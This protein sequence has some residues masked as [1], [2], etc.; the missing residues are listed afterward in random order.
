MFW[1]GKIT[2]RQKQGILTYLRI[3][4]SNPTQADY[5]PINLL[6]SDYKIQARMVERR[7][8]PTIEDQLTYT[9]YCVIPGY[10][11][12]DAVATGCDSIAYAES[13]KK[14]CVFSLD[15]KNAFDRVSHGYLFKIIHGY[16]IGSPLINGIWHLCEGATSSKQIND[17]QYGPIPVRCA[18][19]Q[20]C[21]MSMALYKLSLHSLLKVLEQ[22]LPGLRMETKNVTHRL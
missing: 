6:N 20:D 19:R 13:K 5:R 3:P 10:T 9:Q 14:H 2:S 7:L 15:F 18:V 11:L 17:H 4:R 12:L 1:D 16:G 8:R 22:K 21:P